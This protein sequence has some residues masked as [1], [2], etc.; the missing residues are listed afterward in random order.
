MV[1]IC[2]P[3]YNN[4]RYLDACIRSALDQKYKDVEIVF[5]DDGSAD[6]SLEIAQKYSKRVRVFKNEFNLGQPQNTNRCIEL[7]RGEY[8]VILHSDDMLLP[9]FT[10]KLVPILDRHPNVSMAVGERMLTDERNRVRKITPLYDQDCIIP[11]IRQAKIFMMTS[12]LPCQVLLRRSTFL[13]IG[14]VDP[15]HIINLDGLLWF[16]CALEG[17]VAYIQDPVSIYRIHPKQTT[18]EYNRTISHMMEYYVTLTAM[19]KAGRKHRYLREF[20]GEATRRTATLTLRYTIDVVRERNYDL[21]KSY[22]TLSTVFDPKIVESKEFQEIE[23]CL[24]ASGAKRSRLVKKLLGKRG[25]LRD[26]GFSY[27]PPEK[28]IL[29]KRN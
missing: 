10:S 5:V 19:F 4:G 27:K 21:A 28:S 1:S 23:E 18:S 8:V 16:K 2:I 7:S 24:N 26:R 22:L 13:K 3:N 12:F 17:D 15:R 20:F 9:D 29:L 6:D 14:G 25:K 11:G